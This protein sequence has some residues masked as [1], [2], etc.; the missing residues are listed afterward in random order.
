[1]HAFLPNRV[2]DASTGQSGA[3]DQID[4]DS[5]TAELR[6][7]TLQNPRAATLKVKYKSQAAR[8]TTKIRIRAR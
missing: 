3:R 1:M 4:R 7:V 5:I 6:R 2:L 8:K